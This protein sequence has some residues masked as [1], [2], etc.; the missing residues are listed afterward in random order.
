[1][2]IK[3]V[4]RLKVRKN[5]DQSSYLLECKLK[6]LITD[7]GLGGMSVKGGRSGLEMLVQEVFWRLAMSCILFEQKGV[8]RV[9]SYS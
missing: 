5:I 3:I 6:L 7:F 1:M 4:F 2:K 9:F 8:W